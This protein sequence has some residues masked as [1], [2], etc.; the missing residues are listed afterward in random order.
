MKAFIHARKAIR[1]DSG[2]VHPKNGKAL[3]ASPEVEEVFC[4]Y[5]EIAETGEEVI[6]FVVDRTTLEQLEDNVKKALTID[7]VRI[8]LRDKT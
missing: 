2:W 6:C 3:D 5:A 7:P 1:T 4:I 8:R